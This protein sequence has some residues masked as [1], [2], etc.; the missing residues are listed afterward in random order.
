M[1]RKSKIFALIVLCLA[2][3]A[4]INN[5]N[6]N[7]SNINDFEFVIDF[8]SGEKNSLPRNF[9]DLNEFGLNMI[10]SAQFTEDELKTIIEKYKDRKITIIDLREETHVFLNG[11]SASFYRH[12]H[13]DI[14]K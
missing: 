8:N 7:M 2:G 1:A 12:G 4:K 14:N 11:E 3:C 9:R 5:N 10:A 6:K 13:N